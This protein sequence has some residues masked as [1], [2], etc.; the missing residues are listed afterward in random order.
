MASFTTRVE[1]HNADRDDYTKLHEKM[2]AQGFSQTIR[3]DQGTTYHLPPAEYDY[4]GQV[5]RATVLEKAK[6]AAAAVKPN[7]A[8]LVTES[9]GRT[10]HGLPIAAYV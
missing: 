9:A 7:F 2:R 10:W 8:V 1:L 6:T 3:S 4:S 5:N